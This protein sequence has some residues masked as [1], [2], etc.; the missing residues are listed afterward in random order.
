[1]QNFEK[2]ETKCCGMKR[3]EENI[4]EMKTKSAHL[5]TTTARILT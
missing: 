5:R 4:H 3:I 2:G 1:M